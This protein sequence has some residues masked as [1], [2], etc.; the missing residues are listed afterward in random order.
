MTVQD[1]GEIWGWVGPDIDYV[2]WEDGSVEEL[3]THLVLID[4]GRESGKLLSELDDIG[5]LNWMLK[6]AVDKG[7]VWQEKCVRLRLL[8]LNR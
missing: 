6:D 5:Y 7:N 2:R 1:K 3:A 8:E 4:W